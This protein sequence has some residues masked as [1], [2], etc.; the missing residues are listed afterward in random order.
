MGWMLA[1]AGGPSIDDIS[2]PI[3]DHGLAVGLVV[4]A[5]FALFVSAL[6]GFI[7][8]RAAGKKVSEWGDQVVTGHHEFLTASVATM[9]SNSQL[10]A[11]QGSK[12]DQAVQD[13]LR[14]HD[15]GHSFAAAAS[16]LAEKYPEFATDEILAHVRHAKQRLGGESL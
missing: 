12:I 8:F 10:L 6:A 7:I 1:Q 13:I 2:K 5:V 14:L 11:S 15:A 16:S 4:L 9:N 3:A